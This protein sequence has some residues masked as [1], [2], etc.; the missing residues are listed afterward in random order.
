MHE[1]HDWAAPAST[2][3]AAPRLRLVRSGTT[4]IAPR[5]RSARI[6][7]TIACP[8]RLRIV[9]RSAR[10]AQAM[11][12]AKDN[13]ERRR[14]DRQEG[15]RMDRMEGFLY[16]MSR[17]VFG[18]GIGLALTSAYVIVTSQADLLGP[19]AA[20]ADVVKL[21][22]IV[23]TI[24]AAQFDAIRTEAEPPSTMVHVFGA[25]APTG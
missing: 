1:D 24:P 2:G 9:G 16:S 20:A 12:E 18:L 15:I 5:L 3:N 6:E 8:S 7:S 22:P 17:F 14:L 10:A 25:G 13:E 23:V 11:R 4:P 19:R 21:D